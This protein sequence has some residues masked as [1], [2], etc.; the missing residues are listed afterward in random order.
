MPAA[1]MSASVSTPPAIFAADPAAFVSGDT[2]WGIASRKLGSGTKWTKIY[3]ANASTIEA[4]AKKHGKS[5]SDH[6]HW[7]W[8]GTTLSIPAA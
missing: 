1:V 2:L 7:I 8:P 6:G 5:S 3:D 4:A